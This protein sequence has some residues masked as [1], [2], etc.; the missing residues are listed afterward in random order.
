MLIFSKAPFLWAEAVATAC[1]IYNRSFIRKRHN[2]TPYELLHDRKPDLS[3]LYV[4]GA[5]CYPT[6]DGE[7]FGPGPKLLTLGTI[8]SGLVQNIPSSTPYVPPTKNDW[9]IL[10]QLMFDEY[11]NP[12]SSVDLQVP[13]VIAPEPDKFAKGTADPTLFIRR[14]GKDILLYGMETCDPVDTSMVEKSKLDEDL[15]GKAVDP[16]RYC[17]MIGTLMYL[18][19]SRPDL[20]FVVCPYSKD[21]CTALTSFAN[22]DHA[23]CQDTRKSTFGSMQLLGNKLV[24]WS[25]K[26]LKSTTI[27]CT[28]AEYI[29]SSLYR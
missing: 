24:S 26:K 27:S 3:Y 18:T 5:L 11:L 25:S 4:F 28:K 7:D 14:E 10:F 9:E 21:S 22:V 15:Q 19:S 6:N 20:V 16:T 2:K 29:A 8:S 23:G 17:R 12:P 13:V 1:Y